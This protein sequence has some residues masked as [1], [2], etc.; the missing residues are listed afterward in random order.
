MFFLE[1]CQ[2]H[3]V[4]FFGLAT[5]IDGVFDIS[6][7]RNLSVNHVMV[8]GRHLQKGQQTTVQATPCFALPQFSCRFADCLQFVK[9]LRKCLRWEVCRFTNLHCNSLGKNLSTIISVQFKCHF[10][11]GD[12]NRTVGPNSCRWKPPWTFSQC[13]LVLRLLLCHSA[14]C[15]WSWRHGWP[16]AFSKGNQ[17]VYSSSNSNIYSY[18]QHVYYIHINMYIYMHTYLHRINTYFS[19]FMFYQIDMSNIDQ[20]IVSQKWIMQAH[21]DFL[22]QI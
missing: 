5:A 1:I 9:S 14:S 19:I 16:N 2:I 20:A 15:V 4:F 13:L 11:V 18:I 10:P 21:W 6:W 3:G 17:S 12:R 7:L 22:G 8:A